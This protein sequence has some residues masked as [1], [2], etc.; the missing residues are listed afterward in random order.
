MVKLKPLIKWTGGKRWLVPRLIPIWEHLSTDKLVEPFTGG[1]AVALGL[2]PNKAMLND[3]NVHLINFYQQVRK[4]FVIQH[5][6]KNEAKYYYDIREAFNALLL[7]KKHKTKQAAAMFYYLIRT[8]FNGL[9]RFN[10]NG[11]FNVPFGQHKGIRYRQDFSEYKHYFR[12]WQFKHG[13]FEKLRLAG[14]EL[15]YA[16]PPYDVEFTKY[17]ARDFVWDDQ[18]RLAHWLAEHP[19]P[20]ISSN[21]ATKRIVNLYKDLGFKV[22]RL[23][24]PRMI[25]C[26]GERKP[27]IEILAF[28]NID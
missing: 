13:D 12:D 6:F 23:P 9:C 8:G 11:Q 21:Q 1:M 14:D 4:G 28:K 15:I 20:V 2:N 27:A 25:S 26:T 3:A 10:N 19:G 17:V 7:D 5:E 18:V 22:K 24:A 16:D